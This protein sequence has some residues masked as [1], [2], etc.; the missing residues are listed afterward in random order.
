MRIAAAEARGE[1]SCRALA[2]RFGVSFDYVRNLRRL[3]LR[4]GS[5]ARR[6]QSRHGF[7]SRLN[8]DVKAFLLAQFAAQPDLTIAELRERIEAEQKLPAS[9]STVRRWVL[10]LE[11]RL[12]KSRSTPPSATPK[13]TKNSAR[14]SSPKSA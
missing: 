13:P 2:L 4:T 7:A 9:W 11:L 6:P 8:E 3:R 10:K 12:K 5:A 1:G 14:S